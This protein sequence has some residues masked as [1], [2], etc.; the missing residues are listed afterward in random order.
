MY[1]KIFQFIRIKNSL[2]RDVSAFSLP[3]EKLLKDKSHKID[4]FTV[5]RRK[6]ESVCC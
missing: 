3:V 6:Y 1:I 5:Y 4:T 2:L